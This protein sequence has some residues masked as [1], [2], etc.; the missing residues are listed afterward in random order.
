MPRRH[1]VPPRHLPAAVLL[2]VFV[3]AAAAAAAP[4]PA[5]DPADPS[6]PPTAQ[7]LPPAPPPSGIRPSRKAAER[8]ERPTPP[9]EG[10]APRRAAGR[11]FDEALVLEVR[12]LE[13]PEADGALRA[14]AAELRELERLLAPDGDA[15]GGLAALNAAAG[16]EPVVLDARLL[17]LL[18]RALAFCTWSG[19]A[20][21]P[22]GGGLYA[23]WGLDPMREP[24][25]GAAGRPPA[26]ALRQ[27]SAAAACDRLRLDAASGQAQLAA[28]SRVELWGFARG[29]LVDRAMDVLADH[30]AE[31]A[32]VEL[33]W[34]RRAAGSR[35]DPASPE[36]VGRGWP[37]T[38]PVFPG[39]D[40]PFDRVWLRDEALAVTSSLHRPLLV[41]G[42][43]HA[44]YLDQRSGTPAEGVTGVVTVTELAVDAEAL[45]VAMMIFGN[46]EGLLR[47]GVLE[48]RPAVLWLLGGGEGVPVQAQHNWS[49]IALR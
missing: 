30:G 31:D 44:P 32:F 46:R 8:Q 11:A 48:P 23:L 45:A 29:F 25:S 28:G 35:D 15:G 43:R 36:D 17:D 21:G 1:A 16:G 26:V 20:H 41:G 3:F 39:W 24:S 22:L 6:S 5:A 49:H 7:G 47:A 33:G 12:G 13:R 34:V 19:Q 42:D 40:R 2:A 38:L 14:A 10:P 9:P 18:S 37:V 4:P 27:A